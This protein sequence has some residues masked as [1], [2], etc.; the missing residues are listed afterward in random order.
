MSKKTIVKVWEGA[1]GGV[2][3]KTILSRFLIF[4]PF[5]KPIYDICF[6][7]FRQGRE[8]HLSLVYCQGVVSKN[9]ELRGNSYITDCFGFEPIR[10]GLKF[11]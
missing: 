7:I 2:C 8:D 6:E 10:W 9:P 1:V 3:S 4:G 5:P 11:V